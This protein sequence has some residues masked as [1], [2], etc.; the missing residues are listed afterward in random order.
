MRLV[1][2]CGYGVIQQ[3]V[4]GTPM[5]GQ[6]EVEGHTQRDWEKRTSAFLMALYREM[7][8]V[9]VTN[10]ERF[11][12]VLAQCVSEVDQQYEEDK[13]KARASLPSIPPPREQKAT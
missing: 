4:P 8:S 13:D 10:P 5:P 12:A 3:G 11:E 7:E 2:A 1:E 6:A 9:K